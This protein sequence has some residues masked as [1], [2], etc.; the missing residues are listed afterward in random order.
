MFGTAEG[1]IELFVLPP[2]PL[3]ALMKN[4]AVGS[5]KWTSRQEISPEILQE[6]FVRRLISHFDVSTSDK[7]ILNSRKS[8][9]RAIA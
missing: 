2:P 1:K 5:S 4:P 3:V 9:A 7:R 8:R 6:E